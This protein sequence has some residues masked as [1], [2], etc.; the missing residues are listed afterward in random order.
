MRYFLKS[1]MATAVAVIFSASFASANFW[2]HNKS[3]IKTGNV[4]ISQDAKIANGPELKAGNYKVELL[5][6]SPV[7][8]I[9]FYQ[10]GDLVV[11]T[12][13]KLVKQPTKNDETKVISNTGKNNS[14]T[15]TEIDLRGWNQN[16]VF[17]GSADKMSP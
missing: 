6:E 1:A 17:T 12:T 5:K 11:Q 7:P 8:Q 16:V 2:G 15:I 10:N 4:V 13:A 14:Q 3:A 9:A